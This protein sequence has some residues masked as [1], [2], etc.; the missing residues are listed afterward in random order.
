MLRTDEL[1]QIT[2]GSSILYKDESVYQINSF[3][4][5]RNFNK[6]VV[7]VGGSEFFNDLHEKLLTA[8]RSI[9]IAMFWLSP[10]LYLLRPVLKGRSDLRIM[11]ILKLKA[12]QGVIIKILIYKEIKG[13][14]PNNSRHT[15][16]LLTSLH[17]NIKVKLLTEI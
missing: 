3:A 14:L 10:E 1:V 11:D 6:V 13:S 4:P 7:L 15:Y 9:Y 8:Q 5:E 2:N 12:E 17:P 16:K